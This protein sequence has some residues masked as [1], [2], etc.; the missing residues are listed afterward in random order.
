MT[1]RRCVLVIDK[2]RGCTARGAGRR[3]EEQGGEARA[4]RSMEQMRPERHEAKVQGAR[5][6]LRRAYSL[7]LYLRMRF[8]FRRCRRV[9]SGE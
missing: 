4:S 8:S 9:S 1:D 2:R 6:G 7:P 3:E 5:R